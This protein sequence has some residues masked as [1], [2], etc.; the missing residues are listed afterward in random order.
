MYPV[1]GLEEL[2]ADQ[3]RSIC[4]GE[5]AV[6]RKFPGAFGCVALASN[7]KEDSI[8]VNDIENNIRYLLID[9]K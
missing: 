5:T 8:R 6:A 3:E 7:E 4:V 9:K 1:I 2:G